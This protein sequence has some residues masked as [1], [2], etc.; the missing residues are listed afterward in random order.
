VEQRAVVL[1]SA[2]AVLEPQPE[3]A[4]VNAELMRL[5]DEIAYK[6][7]GV[8]VSTAGGLRIFL[9]I[10]H[11]TME[12][13][14][15]GIR[16][17]HDLM[18]IGRSLSRD[19]RLRIDMGIA[20]NRGYVRYRRPVGNAA[21]TF[22]A[23]DELMENSRLLLD[24]VGDG[25]IV[26]GGGV[27]RLA[28]Q[29]YNFA[30]SDSIE[31]G[32]GAVVDSA[33]Q[34]KVY[35][36]KGPRS[37]RE[38]ILERRDVGAFHGRVEELERLEAAR[39]RAMGD[40]A[41]LVKVVGEI[42]IGKTR[43]I[44][45]FF[46][47]PGAQGA[48]AVTAECLFVERHTPFA[49]ALAAV[50]AILRLRDEDPAA[51]LAAALDPLLRGAPLYLRRQ[52][53]FLSG[54]LASPERTWTRAG[55]HQR[56]LIRRVAFGLGV[57]L[58]RSAIDAG[59]AVLVVENAQWMDGQSA[60]VLSELAS[61]ESRLP[62]LILLVGQPGT[63]SDRRIAG[64]EELVVEELPAALVRE[65]V[66]QRLGVGAEI[67]P[68]SEQIVER[69]QGNPF[70]AGEIIDSLIERG[71]IAPVDADG[72]RETGARFRQARP[73]AIGLPTTMEGLAASH[74]DA[75]DSGIRTTL[76]VA[77][78]IGAGFTLETLAS[79]VGRTVQRDVDTLVE[80]GFLVR[81]GQPDRGAQMYRF[82]RP[83]VREAA[84]VGLSRQD[85]HRL[86]R[87]LAEDLIRLAS[88]GEPVPSAHIAWHL[89]NGGEPER[90]G[91][92]YLE[93]G[94]AALAVYS[95]RR[96]LRLVDRAVLLLSP[97]TEL[98]FDALRRREKILKDLGR[99]DERETTIA[100]LAA[101]A[102]QLE[103]GPK[104]TLAANLAAQLLYDRGEYM[105]AADAIGR[106]IELGA[107]YDEPFNKVESLRL[108]AYT[109]GQVGHLDRALE[110]CNWALGMIPRGSEGLYLRARVLGVKG[111]V[112][113]E[114]G[115]LDGAP[116]FLAEA[117]AIFRNLGKRRNESTA[118]SNIGLA[119]Q[120]RGDLMEG[121]DF[122]ERAVLLDRK[123]KDVSARGRKLA[124]IGNLWLEV[125]ELDKGRSFLE[126]GL[127]ICRDNQE[128]VG[129]VEASLGLAELRL[130]R[131]DPA[132][133]RV[134]LEEVA[135]RGFV[136]RSRILQTR[137]RQLLAMALLGDGDPA[138]AREAAEEATR[139]AKAAGMAGEVV[140]GAV[141]RGMALQHAGDTAAAL[142]AV[143]RLDELIVELGRVR[144]MEEVRWYQAL[145]LRGA[146]DDARSDRALA[147]ARAETERKAAGI[148]SGRHRKAYESHPLVRRILAG[149]AAE[150][151][152][153][154]D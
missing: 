90:A 135:R 122:L 83:M 51:S 128:P 3:R 121:L 102:G 114:M 124:A 132:A 133:A 92:Y 118:M 100:E 80:R 131:D 75:L 79:L 78:A 45:R 148:A 61:L 123:N 59:G 38:R 137:H 89:E 150:R 10:A 9:G 86:H 47:E 18:D 134:I 14:I 129:E 23:E 97:G 55:P 91:A 87:I 30:S 54:L 70:F 31:A 49:T 119:A 74:I 142:A 82:A 112:H 15:K 154:L 34:L 76:R 6:A 19:N 2:R 24:S 106:A 71:I 110:C 130:T 48:G 7:D 16:L 107:R 111:A 22:E 95:N 139:I 116:F 144:R 72:G 85:R 73:G 94:D 109:S 25:E 84:Y 36:V 108:L 58:A 1:V 126:E 81:T 11:S 52:L 103:D 105:R 26:A 17:A 96:A 20:V 77:S 62:V 101:I 117:M 4:A 27:F 145:V 41:T 60:D 13:A 39:R 56:D 8:L 153:G 147:Q 67:D 120:A 115:D 65:I 37:R 35:V 88:A 69:A 32:E 63:L 44:Q 5:A 104:M 152:R 113:L 57:L 138:G 66:Q 125:G 146:G 127:R 151:D 42:G 68:I 53:D 28:R 140:H 93:G 21:P 40:R 29:E 12:D 99:H 33:R 98:R 149:S 143:D 50:R 136:S 43:L 46:E 141:R 64:L